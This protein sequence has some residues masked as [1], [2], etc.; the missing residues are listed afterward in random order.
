M[1]RLH[2]NM[3]EF[4]RRLYPDRI[5]MVPYEKLTENQEPE[6]RRLVDAI[7]LDWD[8]ACLAFH[9][10]TRGVRTASTDQVRRPMYTGSSD[11]WRRYEKHLGPMLQKLEGL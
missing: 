6:S 5:T 3:V 4:W 2:L 10:S 11:V 9:E 7:G 1:Y 8:P